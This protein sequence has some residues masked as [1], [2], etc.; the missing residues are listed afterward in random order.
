MTDEG[1]SRG[2]QLVFICAAVIS[3]PLA[4]QTVRYNSA[5][6]SNLALWEWGVRS[7]PT[8]AFNYQQVWRPIA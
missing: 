2:G 1:A 4:A 3:V 7:D 6:T 5:W 8:S